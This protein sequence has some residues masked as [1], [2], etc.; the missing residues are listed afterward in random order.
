MATLKA[1]DPARYSAVVARVKVPRTAV[2]QFGI[3]E[4]SEKLLEK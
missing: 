1:N 2:L 3:A 4:M